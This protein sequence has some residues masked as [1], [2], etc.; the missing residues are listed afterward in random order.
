MTTNQHPQTVRLYGVYQYT[1]NEDG[2]PTNSVPILMQELL[3]RGVTTIGIESTPPTSS[4]ASAYET[5]YQTDLNER[6][7]DASI[8]IKYLEEEDPADEAIVALQGI[9]FETLNMAETSRLKH[10]ALWKK[11]FLKIK[12]TSRQHPTP[13]TAALLEI[14]PK[15][16]RWMDKSPGQEQTILELLC[17]SLT[18]HRTHTIINNARKTGTTDIV[19][20]P[21]HA[22]N[23][24]NWQGVEIAITKPEP[25]GDAPARE[26]IYESIKPTL[27]YFQKYAEQTAENHQAK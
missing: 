26:K 21:I 24:H 5:Q 8:Q 20:D 22:N 4:A 17:I 13:R 16:K 27:D 12:E 23:A 15:V 18:N 6:C 3:K 14:M 2:T 7:K 25:H 1:I 11:I 9:A 19:L 10:R